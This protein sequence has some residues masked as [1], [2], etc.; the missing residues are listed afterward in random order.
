M[1][2]FGGAESSMHAGQGTIHLVLTITVKRHLSYLGKP[3]TYHLMS[4]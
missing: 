3:M 4:W 2:L 1:P